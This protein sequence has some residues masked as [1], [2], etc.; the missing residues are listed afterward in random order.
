MESFVTFDIETTVNAEG[1]DFKASP[2]DTRNWIVACGAKHSNCNEVHTNY[3]TQRGIW[4]FLPVW[5]AL[6]QDSAAMLVG[7]NLKFDLSYSLVDKAEQGLLYS[8]ALQNGIWDT[9]IAEYML[10]SQQSVMPNLSDT[11]VKYGGEPKID[12]V[13]EHWNNGGKTEDINESLLIEYLEGDVRNTELVARAQI[14]LAKELGMYQAIKAAMLAT[15]AI[16][17]MEC[18]GLHI[19][20][21]RLLKLEKKLDK[22]I[23]VQEESLLK[24]LTEAEPTIPVEHWNINSTHQL[25]AMMFGG[26][27]KWDEPQLIGTYKTGKR[28]GEPKYKK[29]EVQ[30]EIN[31]VRA[32]KKLTQ[33]MKTGYQVDEDTLNRV[34]RNTGKELPNVILNLRKNKKLRDTYCQG[35]LRYMGRNSIVHHN[36]NQAKTITGRLSGSNP[37]MQNIPA[38]DASGIKSLVSSRFGDDGYIVDIDYSQLEVVWQAFVT[39]DKA[40]KEDIRNGVD[41]HVK[42]LALKLGDTY[43]EVYQKA[44]IEKDPE[45]VEMRKKIKV[46]SFQRAYGAGAAAIAENSGLSEDDVKFIIQQEDK[47]YPGVARHLAKVTAIVKNS[48]A[49]GGTTHT[50]EVEGVDYPGLTG[51]YKSITGRSFAF[52]EKP[53]SPGGRFKG[54]SISPTVI[55]NYPIQGGATGDL[56]PLMM[57]ILNKVI[58]TNRE[59]DDKVLL[60]NQVHD[61]IMLDVRKEMLDKAAELCKNILEN[62][63]AFLKYYYGIDFDLPLKVSVEYGPNWGEQK[64]YKFNS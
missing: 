46:F 2:Y 9:M 54:M 28:A 14:K 50:A 42:R 16:T 48:A 12:E 8:A 26:T 33:V 17:V 29:V 10:T 37:N 60:I 19:D 6:K 43:D 22:D 47:V 15:L 31:I 21:A 64:E 61:S 51:Y 13:K 36:L 55:R 63:P 4:P 27:I 38:D 41:F 45:Y 5:Q 18:N 59:F 52:K 44:I 30:R 40:M 23:V 11:A 25:S 49:R 24:L 57:G 58:C 34:A 32:P 39:G 7:H 62:A 56:V 3:M 35:L 53:Y 1:A 20:K